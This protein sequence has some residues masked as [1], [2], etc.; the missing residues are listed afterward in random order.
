MLFNLANDLVYFSENNHIFPTDGHS[1]DVF[2]NCT[3][4]LFLYLMFRLHSCQACV[5]QNYEEEL[6]YTLLIT[7]AFDLGSGFTKKT[8]LLLF[9]LSQIQD[10]VCSKF[11]ALYLNP[12]DILFFQ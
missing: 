5:I 12:W 2:W 8:G 10:F 1:M 4:V 11:L 3:L 9:S 6:E 7:W